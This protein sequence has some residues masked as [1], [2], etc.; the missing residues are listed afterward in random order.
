MGSPPPGT[1]VAGPAANLDSILAGGPMNTL[2]LHSRRRMSLRESLVVVSSVLA[3]AF[4][5]VAPSAVQA[6]N[7]FV[8]ANESD[9]DTMDPH[10]AFDVGRVAVRLNLY[11]GLMRWQ[12]NPAVLVPWVA[13]SHTISSDG[14]IYTFKMRRDVKF[15]DGSPVSADDVVYSME[16]ILA[17]GKGAAAVFKQMIGPGQTRAVDSHTVE[18]KLSKPS[19]I[20]LSMVPEVHILNKALVSKHE[21]DG[22]L[23]AAWLSRNEAGSGAFKL[24]QFDPAVGFVAERYPEHFMGWGEKY[25]DEIE[26]RAVKDTNTRVLGLQKGDF[27]GVGGYLQ[28]DLLKKLGEG[29]NTK[30]LE[31][32]SM[33][34]MLFQINN[35]RPPL[36]DVHVRRA[37]NHAF[38]YD[39]FNKEILGGLVERNPTPLPNTIWGNPK[40]VKG[41]DYSIEKAKAEL[42]KASVKVDRPLEIVYLVGFSQSEQAAALLQNGLTKVGIESKVVGVPWPTMVE[43]AAK[44]E[45][46]PDL[47]VYWI[48][49]YYADPHNWVGEMYHSGAWGTFKSNSFY[50]NPKVD[51]LL[52]QALRSTDQDER[53]KLYADA[54]RIVVED[55]A[56]LWIYNTKWYGPY[57]KNLQGVRFCPIGNAQEMRT[58]YYQ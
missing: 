20:F 26:F 53:A 34:I 57:S 2:T 42:A 19:A 36:T 9:Y 28:S 10:A 23:G 4:G 25:L 31:A 11:D 49:T 17:M 14:L 1:A 48:S 44:P 5:A 56:G 3:L 27:N 16:R 37:I 54:T 32:E 38:D 58:A 8:F 12:D 6:K 35:Q 13:E 7:R 50:K 51:A 47:S 55:A 45:T 21:K 39:G 18:F 52:D 15:H 33:R 46:N 43:K 41:Y 22:D 40:D 30:V 29:A 24:K